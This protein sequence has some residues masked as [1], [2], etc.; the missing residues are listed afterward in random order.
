MREPLKRPFRC[1]TCG[2]RFAQPQ[3]LNRHRRAKHNPSLCIL[4]NFEWS[5]PYLYRGLLETHHT[6]VDPDEIIGKT[7]DS[8]R[9][10]ASSAGRP[11][12]QQ[13]L[14]P[15]IEHYGRGDSE[16]RPYP[17]MLRPPAVVK[18][19]TV[20]PSAMSS[21]IYIPQSESVQSILAKSS[22]EE[23]H[24]QST[25]T[26]LLW[27]R[28][29]PLGGYAGHPSN[30]VTALNPAFMPPVDGHHGSL[31]DPCTLMHSPLL[32]L[33]KSGETP[34]MSRPRTGINSC[35]QWAGPSPGYHIRHD[36]AGTDEVV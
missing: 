31:P 1:D 28:S 20:I 36:S 27:L 11:Q 2:D 17:P 26:T 12:Q 35:R 13:V 34:L 10:A 5:R 22:S 14:P 25:G 19:A 32:A 30:L 24:P 9:R 6:E 29:A 16:I 33:M 4:Y 8:R 21:M 7:A 18:P 3:G 23:G 15:T